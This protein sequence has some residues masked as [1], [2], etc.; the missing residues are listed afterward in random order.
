[1]SVDVIGPIESG[2][3]V[4]GAGVATI[5]KTMGVDAIG[6]LLSVYVE[7]TGDKPGTTDVLVETLGADPV[8]PA[9]TLLS[10]VDKVTDGWFHPRLL[11]DT[12]LGVE[13]AN[14]YDYFAVMDKVKVTLAQANTDDSVRVW[15]KVWKQ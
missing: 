7:Y 4:G 2:A 5:S 14:V 6:L 3:A 10:L 13:V 1:M 9:E 15:L 12:N 8:A 11:I